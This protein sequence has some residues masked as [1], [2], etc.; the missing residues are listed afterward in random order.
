[1]TSP[2]RHMKLLILTGRLF[3]VLAF[4]ALM[5]FLMLFL[6][7]EVTA[8]WYMHHYNIAARNELSEDYG[9]GMLAFAI[10]CAVATATLFFAFF[11]GWR[12]SGRIAR[13]NDAGSSIAAVDE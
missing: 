4:A 9:F 5:T 8:A 1:M 3:V 11:V 6:A 2:H 7:G 10:G 12:F 13:T